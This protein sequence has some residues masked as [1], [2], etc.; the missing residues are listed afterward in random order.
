MC[1]YEAISLENLAR[2]HHYQL[3]CGGFE[4]RDSNEQVFPTC[5]KTQTN[6]PSS[7]IVDWEK[8]VACTLSDN[9]T[10]KRLDGHKCHTENDRIDDDDTDKEMNDNTS[11]RN[12]NNNNNKNNSTGTL[13]TLLNKAKDTITNVTNKFRTK[14]KKDN[15]QY[16]YDD[17]KQQEYTNSNTNSSTNDDGTTWTFTINI[18]A[19]IA[20]AFG[21]AIGILGMLGF[22]YNNTKQRY[23]PMLPPSSALPQLQA[24]WYNYYDTYYHG[25]YLPFGPSHD[26]NI[27]NCHSNNHNHNINTNKTPTLFQLFQQETNDQKQNTT[28]S[29]ENVYF[30]PVTLK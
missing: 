17:D 30:V 21:V 28:C 4:K 15:E 19:L 12:N 16:D 18:Q 25:H 29:G 26:N 14:Y 3:V 23:H 13:S 10:N 6:P 2:D 20:F 27:H 9:T 22:G 8:T 24:P 5:I 1:D 11:L 7:V